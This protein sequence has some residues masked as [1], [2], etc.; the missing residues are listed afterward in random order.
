[1][2]G[3]RFKVAEEELMRGAKRLNMNMTVAGSLKGRVIEVGEVI[4]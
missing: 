2:I 3:F 1:M 4:G